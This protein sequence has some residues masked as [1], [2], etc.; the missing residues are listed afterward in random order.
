MKAADP[1]L[2]L[3]QINDEDRNTRRSATAELERMLAADPDITDSLIAMI[4]DPETLEE[5]SS[6]GRYN[7]LYLLTE[8]P[9]SA[10]TGKRRQDVCEALRLIRARE[11]QGIR[12][13]DQTGRAML[14][15]EAKAGSCGAR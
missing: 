4:G 9:E 14:D 3:S 7:V 12:V 13:G 15:I 2:L 1:A 11:K 5:L 6:Q 8:A 10:W